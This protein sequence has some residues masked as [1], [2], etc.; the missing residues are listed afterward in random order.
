MA[1]SSSS[2][3]PCSDDWKAW[4]VPWKEVVTVAGSV[5]L[6]AWLTSLTASPRD[7]P[8]L[9]LNDKVTDGAWPE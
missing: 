3:R 6:A 9:R 8:G 5:V 7:V 2:P 4:A 1:M